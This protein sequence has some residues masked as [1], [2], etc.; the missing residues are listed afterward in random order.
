[1]VEHVRKTD[2]R[3]VPVDAGGWRHWQPP[4]VG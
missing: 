1:V 2:S 4:G 3:L